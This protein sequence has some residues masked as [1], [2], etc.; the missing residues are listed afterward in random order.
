[1]HPK[2]LNP[3]EYLK[4]K[5]VQDAAILKTSQDL[6]RIH[7]AFLSKLQEVNDLID[8]KVGPQGI[9]GERGPKGDRGEPGD[10]PDMESIIK[11]VQAGLKIPKD[12]KDGKDGATPEINH[13]LIATLAHEKVLKKIK[14]PK[15]GKDAD[16]NKVIQQLIEGKHIKA[17]HIEGLE[18]TM[19][20]WSQQLGGIGGKT[21][22]VHGGGDTIKQGTNVT[23]TTDSQGNKVISASGTAGTPVYE[24]NIT[25][26]GTAFTLA[27]TPLANSLRLYRGGARQR[28]T[29]DYTISGA[30]ITL[31]IAKEAGEVLIADYN[32]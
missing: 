18:Q 12:G 24:E 4:V 23:I 32:H 16:I 2:T 25:G 15:D 10:T 29:E 20:A 17:E 11:Y 14:Q 7:D 26:T 21:G 27:H 5:A 19:R 8:K 13:D 1:M 31:S 6:I 9:R 30:D 28:L 3:I 22:Y